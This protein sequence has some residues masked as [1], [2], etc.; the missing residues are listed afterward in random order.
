VFYLVFF[1]NWILVIID[2]YKREDTIL[3]I[4]IKSPEIKIRETRLGSITGFFGNASQ[5]CEMSKGKR[6]CDRK[7]SFSQCLGCS[8]GNA[9][10][11]LVMIQDAVVI[12]HA[13][14][15]CSADFSD[16]NFTN[17]V[18]QRKRNF[19]LR[20]ARLLSTNLEEKDT[21]YG[22]GEKLKTT[23]E[24]A[25]NRFN[26]KAIFITAS[27]ASGI[28][29]DD[30]ETIAEDAEKKF[31]IPVVYIPC[32]GFKS[33]MWTTG[34]DAAYH[35]I[36]RKI[37][38]PP[39]KK[40]KDLINVINFWGSDIFTDLFGK[41]GLRPNYIVPFSTIEQLQKMSEAAATVQICPTLGTYLAAALEQEYGVQEVKAPPAYGIKGTDEWFR[42]L[43]RITGKE[44][45]VEEL[46]KSE[47][48]KIYPELEKLRSRLKGKRAYITAGAAHGHSL[49][50]LLEDLGMKIVGASIF[51]HDPCYDNGAEAAKSLDHAINTYGDIEN[52]S[53]CDKQAYE[54]VNSLNRLKPDIFVARHGGMSIWGAKLGIPTFLMGD[55][56]FGL[57]YQGLINYG[58]KVL[59][60]LETPEFVKNI[61]AH[62]K[63]PYTDW[64]FKQR[65]DTFL[66]EGK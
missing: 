31:K 15:G 21:I 65:P 11:Q 64:W 26:P 38:K 52:F 10:C 56:Q 35:G 62:A 49:M 42:E 25:F 59:D 17:R 33:K 6:L 36:I 63:F 13:P 28:I 46:I 39:V 53:V 45:E 54:L 12:N 58:K 48:E 32:E 60:V 40:Q 1:V 14:L 16:F 9:L 50:A 29:G 47:K 41:I 19:K 24:E 4:N 23:I 55:E 43:G 2:K 18:G 8:S 34:F 66:K 51:H 7:H 27:C 20:N 3:S 57:G 37:V 30:I 5:L 61:A 22:G 44:A